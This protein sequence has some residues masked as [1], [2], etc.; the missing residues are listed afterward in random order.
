MKRILLIITLVMTMLASSISI[1]AQKKY[2]SRKT[3]ATT[4]TQPSLSGTVYQIFISM[5]E[6]VFIFIDKNRICGFYDGEYYEPQPVTIKNKTANSFDIYLSFFEDPIH[7]LYTSSSLSIDDETNMS[8]EKMKR[9]DFL[10]LRDSENSNSYMIMGRKNGY[11]TIVT[12]EP[13]MDNLDWMPIKLKR[14][15]SD[16]F[17]LEYMARYDGD[18]ELDSMP[19]MPGARYEFYLKGGKWTCVYFAVPG[20]TITPCQFIS[21]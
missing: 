20:L 15:T 21:M 4:T 2:A 7:C 11:G 16:S 9:N 1:Q 13:F 12:S 18:E 3:G 17:Q 6:V 14:C 10:F 5:N 19:A 8:I